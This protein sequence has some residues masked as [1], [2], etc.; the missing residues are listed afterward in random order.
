MF[1][2]GWDVCRAERLEQQKR[3]G[4]VPASTETGRAIA[5]VPAWEDLTDAERRLCTSI[6]EAYAAMLEHADVHIGRL[7]DFIERIGKRDDTIVLLLSD[8]GATREGGTL[9]AT[10]AMRWNN[11]LPPLAIEDRLAQ[12]DRVGG[13]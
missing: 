8:N 3:L 4:I 12:L 5:D 11:A 10:N 9:G 6:Q 2:R 13:P 1:D 7:L